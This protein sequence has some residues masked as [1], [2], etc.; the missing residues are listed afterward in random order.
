MMMPSG[1]T[2]GVDVAALR[3]RTAMPLRTAEGRAFEDDT[4]G[5]ILERTLVGD[6]G[7]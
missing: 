7:V 4:F 5:H 1:K 2:K 6:V 3:Q